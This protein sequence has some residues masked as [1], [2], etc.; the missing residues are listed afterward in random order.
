MR[1]STADSTTRVVM[2]ADLVDS[3]SFRVGHGDAAADALLVRFEQL[4]EDLVTANDG[5]VVANHGDGFL[6]SFSSASSALRCATALR[7]AVIGMDFEVAVPALRIGIS[8]GDV[9]E[10]GRE[11]F[12]LPVVVAARLESVAE[13]GEIVC[14]DLVRSLAGTRSPVEFMHRRLAELKGIPDPVEVWTVLAPEL[15]QLAPAVHHV[16]EWRDELPVVA[17]RFFGRHHEQAALPA[18]ISAGTITTLLGPG[19]VGKTRLSLELA[20]QLKAQFPDGVWFVELESATSLDDVVSAVG[21]AMR[22][23]TV[24]MGN[25]PAELGAS[26]RSL[27]AL[28]ILDNC[29]Q[30]IDDVAQVAR[31]LVADG[32]RLAVLTSSREVLGLR[33]EV[34]WPLAP[35]EVQ[36]QDES[37]ECHSVE[38]F[39]D[40]ATARNVT[41]EFS[42]EDRDA[43]RQVVESLEGLPLAIELAASRLNVFSPGEMA[44][45]SEELVALLAQRDRDRPY[46]HQTLANTVDWSI[47]LLDERERQLLV[48]VAAFA[49][50]A[51]LDAIAAVNPQAGT[52]P[53]DLLGDLVDKSLLQ[54]LPDGTFR[55]LAVI[56][57]TVRERADSA[58][59]LAEA[60]QLHFAY[61]AGLAREGSN[62]VQHDP[63]WLDRFAREHEN[64]MAALD[65]AVAHDPTQALRMAG[66]LALYWVLS[67]NATEGD[68]RFARVLASA[69]DAD[70]AVLAAALRG[71]GMAA[72]LDGRYERSGEL[73]ADARRR[74]KE[75]GRADAIAYCDH[76]VARNTVVQVH[77]GL[78]PPLALTEAQERL[79]SAV[80]A[81]RDGEDHFGVLLA[82]PYLGWASLLQGDHAEALRLTGE[83]LDLAGLAGVSLVKAYAIGHAAFIQLSVGDLELA[84]ENITACL[85]SLERTGDTQ[86]LVITA[87]VNTAIQTRRGDQQA[88]VDAAIDLADHA[89]ACDSVEWE[90]AVLSILAHV[91]AELGDWDDAGVLGDA[92]ERRHPTW[93]TVLRN[94][95][96]DPEITLEHVVASRAPVDEQ[97]SA[98][99]LLR[100]AKRA[101]LAQRG[102]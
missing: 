21:R 98:S 33:Q 88:T 96:I 6:T 24:A 44:R 97:L 92:L 55:M 15:E 1:G 60:F 50:A 36:E 102:R 99:L 58:D 63:A 8:A 23:P 22:L 32:S 20:H 13:P 14:S 89:L 43:I 80:A 66:N 41:V 75:L 57:E 72:A 56:R 100:M 9:V 37:S 101:L 79:N 78:L 4:A 16:V 65:H 46:R 61:F 90:P 7:A 67:G 74:Y 30:A 71:A 17:N 34:V 83:L 28:V 54:R 82:Y 3:T 26:L 25:G 12:G 51:D 5:R 45:R 42:A 64:L 69:E 2:V 73:F 10:R 81:F 77:F 52:L 76:W 62:L 19:G 18:Q 68:R 29:E 27:D 84:Q 95:G 47:G 91:L 87:C 35:L 40:R 49:G 11:M 94:T 86:N 48:G 53:I 85:S 39:I 70:P 31:S 93:R 38:L 59:R